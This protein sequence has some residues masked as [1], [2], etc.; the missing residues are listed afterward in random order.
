MKTTLSIKPSLK[1]I[2]GLFLATTACGF[3][4]ALSAA[5]PEEAEGLLFLKQEEKLARDVYLALGEQWG[6]TTFA[7]IAVSEQRHMDA[8]DGLIG[9]FGLDD[10]TP[11]EVGQFSIPE[12]QD[13]YEALMAQGGESIEAALAVGV[14]IE[15]TDIE[16]ID[17][18]LAAVRDRTIRQVL[19]NLRRGSTNHLA[20]FTRALEALDASAPSTG[21]CDGTGASVSAGSVSKA[22]ARKGPGRTQSRW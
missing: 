15:E 16:D 8:V 1:T 19:T 20:A 13:L 5:T 11:D 7:N 10:S 2:L 12:L 21:T 4:P 14:L 18:L 22:P 17:A 3:A 6:H 9:R